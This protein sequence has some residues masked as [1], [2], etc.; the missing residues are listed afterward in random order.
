MKKMEQSDLSSDGIA[1]FTLLWFG[2]ANAPTP[3]LTQSAPQMAFG[4]FQP[5]CHSTPFGQ[6]QT[7]TE[8]DRWD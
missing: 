3:R 1:Y 6:T 8:T 5:F 4:S 2:L 7:H